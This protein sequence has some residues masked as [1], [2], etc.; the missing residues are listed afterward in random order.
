[1]TKVQ[2]QENRRSREAGGM[3]VLNDGNFLGRLPEHKGNNTMKV[4]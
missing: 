3:Y 4:G 2:G 1:M